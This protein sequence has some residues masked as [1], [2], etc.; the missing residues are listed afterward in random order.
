MRFTI[1]LIII[2]LSFLDTQ[3]QLGQW[4]KFNG[5]YGGA[6]NSVASDGSYIAAGGENGIFISKNSGESWNLSG[7][8][9]EKINKICVSDNY[10]F[11]ATESG[12]Y[13]TL[14]DNLS[15]QLLIAGNIYAV[16]ALDSIIF[17]GSG[18][19]GILRSTD[20]GNS[21]KAVNSGLELQTVREIYIYSAYTCLAYVPGS[22]NS[23]FYRS[24]TLGEDWQEITDHT[25]TFFSGYRGKLYAFNKY[26]DNN[27][28]CSTDWGRSWKYHSGINGK[29][30][31]F[32]VDSDGI[33]A[34]S[35]YT[36][37]YKISLS[38]DKQQLTSHEIFNMNFHSLTSDEEYLY[39][40]TEDGIYRMLK[41]TL[42]WEE[43]SNGITNHWIT[44]I[45]EDKEHLFISTIGA[46]LFREEGENFVKLPLPLSI[47]SVFKI[48]F[49]HNRLYIFGGKK[50]YTSTKSILL[51]TNGG[52]NWQYC[53]DGLESRSPICISSNENYV[54]LGTDHGLFRKTHSDNKW[55]LLNGG[56]PEY[57]S[58]S[59]ISCFDSRILVFTY[60]SDY[61]ISLDNGNSWTKKEFNSYQETA[62]LVYID[63]NILYITSRTPREILRSSDMGESWDYI[64]L[65]ENISRTNNFLMIGNEA[66]MST[67][68]S[69]VV[70]INLSDLSTTQYSYGLNNEK[71]T[72]I[73][74]TSK[75]IIAGSQFGGAYRLK[76]GRIKLTPT[77]SKMLMN[78]VTLSWDPGF[79]NP[80][81]IVQLATD[82]NF[83]DIYYQSAE[84]IKNSASIK[85]LDYD[86]HYYWRVGISDLSSM[87]NFTD[88][89][90]FEIS[91]P[92]DYSLYQN[93]PNP[94]NIETTLKF[95]LPAK[96]H[97]EL[98][99]FDILGKK[100]RTI[101]S[102]TLGAGT[103][104]IP[105]NCDDLSS[106]VYVVQIKAGSFT[107]TKKIILIK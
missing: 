25:F 5:P 104:S 103:H 52:T 92:V 93:Y 22:G 69:Y 98:K 86:K 7:L 32:H 77:S 94:F 2:F 106:A 35:Q 37:V 99:L 21:W 89:L 87:I 107:D 14:K 40:A 105:L 38:G 57:I 20:F 13:R 83:Q 12:L 74:K 3:A 60:N 50:A 42:K 27:I 30:Q 62:T 49:A 24:T 82:D 81:F 101:L 8:T 79:N 85:Y 65:M 55:N 23:G 73:E 72:C 66:L 51:S 53:A 41:T 17:S 9:G 56:L 34:A 1:I 54:Y 76:S 4:E 15:W 31:C 29:L 48:Y 64:D 95:D 6:I 100:V 26:G 59:A 19:G 45:A 70:S 96:I 80:P 88:P 61:Y 28:S 16:S 43:K 71:V 84:L 11:A 68:Y 90:E 46:G 67:E 44:D 18:H 10:I 91:R 78:N 47:F 97:T 33:F 75:G 63:N 36:G 102:R 39:A 58:I